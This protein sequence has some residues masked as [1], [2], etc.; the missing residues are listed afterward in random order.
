MIGVPNANSTHVFA[1]TF[2]FQLVCPL[3]ARIGVGRIRRSDERSGAD[4]ERIWDEPTV[5]WRLDNPSARY[6]YRR[7]GGCCEVRAPTGR[8]LIRA[9]LGE[10]DAAWAPPGVGPTE[11]RG[12]PGSVR[13]HVT[14]KRPLGSLA[15]GVATARSSVYFW[16]GFGSV[17]TAL[18]CSEQPG[19]EPCERTGSSR[20][21]C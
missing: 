6:T 4:Y 21:R 15:A 19:V 13:S 20:P 17:K 7:R 9:L 10:V 1:T 12:T 5:R 18:F 8:P 11:R 16:S 3:Q 2:G 14:P